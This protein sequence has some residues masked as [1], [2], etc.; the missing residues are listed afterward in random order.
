[1]GE[2]PVGTVT[3]LFT[4]VEGSTRLL[5]ELGDA[6]ADALAEHRRLLRDVFARH[7]GA[8]VD[9]QGDALFYAFPDAAGAVDA[10]RD[11]QQA[12]ASGPISVRMG[13]HTGRA[14]LTGEGYVGVE[15]H[16]GARIAAAGH[17]RQ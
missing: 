15:V 5:H 3:F 13:L 2:P 1:M 6:Y 4:D 16:K 8:E 11:G 9:T 14:Q 10:A 7:G 12:L 17:G